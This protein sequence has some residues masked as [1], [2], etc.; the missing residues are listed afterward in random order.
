[1]LRELT[2]QGTVATEGAAKSG[3]LNIQVITPGWG[4][5]GYYSSTVLEQAARDGV[6]SAGTQMYLDHPTEDELDK[7][8]NRSV[9]DL[10]AVLTE[11]AKWTGSALVAQ[12]RTFGPYR[13][14]VA[15]MSDAIGVS[16]RADAEVAEGEAEGKR[17]LL[18]EK[19]TNA[20]SVDFVTAAG[21]GGR[22]LQ[23][24]ES[25]REAVNASAV[26]HG[27]E[28]ATANDTREMLDRTLSE[29]FGSKDTHIWVRDFD[30]ETVW[31]EKSS[32][33]GSYATFQASYTATETTAEIKGNPVKVRARTS[34]VPLNEEAV[35]EGSPVA[36]DPQQTPTVAEATGETGAEGAIPDPAVVADPA[37]GTAETHLSQEEKMPEEVSGSGGTAPPVT[38]RS[39]LMEQIEEQ[40]SENLRLKAREKARGI[41]HEDLALAVLTPLIIQRLSEEL[42]E[43]LP[44]PSGELDVVALRDRINAKRDRAELEL[45]EALSMHGAAGQPRSLGGTFTVSEG[46]KAAEFDS[47][48]ERALVGAFGLSEKAA[49]VAVE[50][51]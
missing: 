17:G 19:L 9:K 29:K 10:A 20:R 39:H 41:I 23:V 36:D 50:G 16:I 8:P 11:D 15:E 2:E 4:S 18:V 43:N 34:Y 28:E 7:R 45:G 47:V 12:A 30:G 51:R 46:G 27:V 3:R 14:A 38:S 35:A 49:H 13:D 21:R 25:A 1:M 22:I 44:M 33:D 26:A 42:I 5:S 6:F 48:T 32:K 37:A 24:L 40:R 31:Y